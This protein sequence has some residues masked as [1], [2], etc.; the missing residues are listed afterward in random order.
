MSRKALGHIY[1]PLLGHFKSEI[2]EDKHVAVISSVSKSGLKFRLWLEKLVWLLVKQNKE[3]LVGPAFCHE[4]G[5]M[6]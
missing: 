1:V 4:D 3:K 2:G 5:T 6:L